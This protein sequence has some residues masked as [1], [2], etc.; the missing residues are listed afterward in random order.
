MVYVPPSAIVPVHAAV[1]VAGVHPSPPPHRL[2]TPAPPQS[3]GNVQVGVDDEA[4]IA[5]LQH[6][7]APPQPSAIGPHEFAGH[8]VS[9]VHVPPPS[10]PV[11]T[12]PPQL[13]SVPPPP[14]IAG[15]V[16]VPQL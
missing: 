9:G 2:G 5:P 10:G 16:H 12:P 11:T 13:S 15:S 4:Q 8:V 7:I 6:W 3:A 14:Q 1:F